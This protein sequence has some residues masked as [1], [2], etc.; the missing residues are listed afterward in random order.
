MIPPIPAIPPGHIHAWFVSLD[1]NAH[2]ERDW[3]ALLSP[4]ERERAAQFRFDRDRDRYIA[5]HGILRLILNSYLLQ[6]PS[7]IYGANGK[8]ALAC[9]SLH[10]NLSHAED[11]AVIAVSATAELGVDLERVR[12]ESDADSIAEICFSPSERRALSLLPQSLQ[13]EAFFKCWTRKEALV[14]ALGDGLS[15]PLTA[16]SVSLNEPPRILEL[17]GDEHAAAQWSVRHLAPEPG[18]VGA[19]VA[20]HPILA[21]VSMSL[22]EL[23]PAATPL[24]DRFAGL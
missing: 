9:G 16:F 18:Y 3:R 11:R 23:L 1:C 17:A 24:S 20:R 5:A 21:V 7:L 8:P 19:I 4:E 12:V 13:A 14:K 10:F 15:Y 22:S 6:L 2:G